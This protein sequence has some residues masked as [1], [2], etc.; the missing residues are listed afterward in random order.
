M[1]PS[2]VGFEPPVA[3][4]FAS[5]FRKRCRRRSVA[6]RLKRT[7][8]TEAH[9]EAG[10]ICGGAGGIAGCGFRPAC[11]RKRSAWSGKRHWRQRCDQAAG[12]SIASVARGFRL[13]AAGN[14]RIEG[15][16]VDL[17]FALSDA[18]VA[19]ATR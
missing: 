11:G 8:L 4:I 13:E 7:A 12:L 6:S 9:Q 16:S 1:R 3:E 14:I 2:L 19:S 18:R 15:L 5:G 17:Q 10:H